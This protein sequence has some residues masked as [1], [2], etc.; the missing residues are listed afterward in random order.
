MSETIGLTST[1]ATSQRGPM[2]KDTDGMWWWL[3]G[4]I[5]SIAR[6]DNLVRVVGRKRGAAA[7]EIDYLGPAAN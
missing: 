1:I 6:A 5:D 4:E 2:L 7:I 3:I